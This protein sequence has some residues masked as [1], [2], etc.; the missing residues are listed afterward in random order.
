MVMLH[1][2][3]SKWRR[4]RRRRRRRVEHGNATRQ[5]KWRRRRRRRGWWWRRR[6]ISLCQAQVRC[7]GIQQVIAEY[8]ISHCSSPRNQIQRKKQSNQSDELLFQAQTSS[9]ILLFVLS[10]ASDI[11]WSA[12]ALM[13]IINEHDHML[14]TC[15]VV[16][17]TCNVVFIIHYFQHLFSPL[18]QEEGSSDSLKLRKQQK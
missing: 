17:I 18:N 6:R 13:A 11:I 7:L 9:L 15:S 16:F 5:S 2:R 1:T 8:S 10:A 4:R 14:V 12:P 3:L